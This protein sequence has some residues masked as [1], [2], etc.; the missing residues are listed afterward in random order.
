MFM[1]LRI[2]QMRDERGWTQEV[3]AAK[4]GISRSQLAMIEKGTR[5]ANTLRLKSIAN[6]FGVPTEALFD[7]GDD[8]WSLLQLV[9]QLTPEDRAVVVRM[10]E[11][12]AA[13][14]DQN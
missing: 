11:A 8:D 10:A 7:S 14:A 2:K 1:G 3:L 4:T 6:A 13:K 5:P 9:K 12:L